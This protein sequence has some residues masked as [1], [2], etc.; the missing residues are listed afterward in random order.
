MLAV[1]AIVAVTYY[2]ARPSPAP[3]VLGYRKL[4]NDGFIKAAGIAT[5][6]ARVYFTEARPADNAIV[7]VS[8]SGGEAVP[9]STFLENPLI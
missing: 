2:L 9:L 1:A 4:T 3:R 7:Q 8:T 5:D 6:G